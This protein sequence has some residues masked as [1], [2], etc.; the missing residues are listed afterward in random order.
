MA[1]QTPTT[2]TLFAQIVAGFRAEL[3]GA[4]GAL[5]RNNLRPLA[6]VLAGGL[7]NIHRF[8]AWA[9][10]QAFVHRCD[11]AFL[12]RHG[13]QM[14]P[15]VP[16]KPASAAQGVVTVVATTSCTIATGAVL[17]RGDGA[18]YTVAAGIVLGAPGTAG[19][20]VVAGA[21]GLTGN[22]DA[23]TPLAATSGLSGSATFT[24]AAGGLGGGAETESDAAYRARLLFARAFPE[25]AGAVPDWYRYTLAVP[26]VATCFLDPLGAGRGTVVVYPIFADRTNGIGNETD[27]ALVQ[28]ALDLARP[29][30]GL[31]VVM[32]PQ[33]VPVDV[34]V[35][36][37]NPATPEVRLAVQQAIIEVFRSN[38]RVAGQ[39]TP[40]PSMPFLAT[41]ATFSRSWLWQAVANATGEERHSLTLPAADVVLAEGQTATLGQLAFL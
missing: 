22:A 21:T 20:T 12:D 1:W 5:R 9:A 11:A 25:H 37:L 40:H 31:P 14:K 13:A 24:V 36:G 6:K 17:T 26:G 10:D 39:A 4:D 3:P 38:G 30:A 8:A 15:P 29:G 16:R 23:G 33:A 35:T 28:S 18:V 41:P 34:A 2:E 27:R 32:L 19:V 7:F